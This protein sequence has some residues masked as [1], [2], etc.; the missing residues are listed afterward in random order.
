MAGASDEPDLF[1]DEGAP[2][3]VAI[4]N[5]RCVLRTQDGHRVVLI[6]GII[7]AQYAVGDAMAE[8]NAMVSLVDQ[9]W[10]DQVEVS[11]AF[12]C[13]TRTVR[14]YLRRF[15]EGGLAALG[16]SGGYPRGR[17][18][19]DSS[20]SRLVCRL[21]AAGHSNREIARR[22]GVSEVA[23]RKLL[24]RLG[25]A[26]SPPVQ[27]LLP[28]DVPGANP[29]LSASTASTVAAVSPGANPNLSASIAATAA[30]ASPSANPNMSASTAS[31]V[32]AVSPGAN[33]NLSAST[34]TAE[35]EIAFTLDTDPANRS[36]DRLLACLGLIDDAAPLFRSG[37]RVP[38]AGVLLALPAIIDSGV[39]DIVRDIYGSI[40]PAFY[41][42][43][44]TLVALLLM[45]LLRIKRP[46]GLKEHLP[47]DLG[48]LL[49]LDRA[50]EMK[51][52]RR[53]LTR[54]AA[55]GQ[56][57]AFGRALAQKRVAT[58]GA[59]FGFLYVDGHVRVY[60]GKHTLP[61]T[62]VAQMRRAMPATS[63]YW[64][65]DAAGEPLF[66]LTAEANAGMVKMLPIVL[67]EIRTL[68]P[69]RRVTVV[70]DRGGW[71]PKLFA[72][73]IAQGFDVLTYRKG[74]FPRIAKRRF[75]IHT[76]L[77]DGRERRYLLAEHKVRFLGGKLRLRQVTL[78]SD[79]GQHQT[80]ILTSRMDL[81]LVEVAFR[82]FERWRQ[83]N[84]F[85]Y[86]REEYALDALV[87]Y[88]VEPD[89]P[90]RDVPNPARKALDKELAKARDELRRVRTTY[91][92]AAFANPEALRPT[93]RGFKNA[94]AHLG[95]AIGAAM[96]RVATLE[97]R[98]AKMP[99]RVPVGQVVKGPVLKLA[100]ERK[101]LTNL[102]KM[103]AYQAESD[104]FRLVVPHYKRAEDEGRTLIQSALNG[105]ATIEVIDK[106]LRITLAPLS[107][108]H[109][110]RAIAELCVEMDQ[111]AAMFP[112][113]RLRLRYA[114]EGP[115]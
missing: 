47:E 24:R 61:K 30:T 99:A 102:F 80:P 107:S 2:A 72:T 92:I 65:N 29:N 11:H 73:L 100:T 114:V 27:G 66:V 83:E 36:A 49:G 115:P 74:R 42:L 59:A 16:R 91:G 76:A 41:G 81:S 95:K 9:G 69:G 87:D 38:R 13:A 67:A 23:V 104:L 4:I 78:L 71:S 86:L 79:D 12:E 18:R 70:F 89:N 7:L 14:R 8:A 32:A 3:G 17:P 98:R 5:E 48:R 43:R 51:T 109:R 96:R 22:I 94:H 84:F 35:E 111:R 90:Q 53:K 113:T 60:H 110:T 54:L 58:R 34:L 75:H 62:H 77:I 85:K 21:K 103:L 105:P 63:D 10:A 31:T 20:R 33:P 93:M 52:L 106:E 39:L 82:M 28:I 50:P 56:A 40:G 26:P 88:Q 55:L 108:A 19:V 45:A 44:T 25:W 46:E 112:G 101:L 6:C 15:E 64:V 97:Q 37:V 1:V 57:G 68:L